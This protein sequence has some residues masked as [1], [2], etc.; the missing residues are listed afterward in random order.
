MRK[1]FSTKKGKDTL[2][3]IFSVGA[4]IVIFGALAKIE[5]WDGIL[6]HALEIGMITETF[7]FMLMAL[8]PPEKEYHWDRFYPNITESLEEEQERTG[9]SRLTPIPLGGHDNQALSSF[10]SMLEKAEITPTNLKKLSDNF[11]KFG[12]TVDKMSEISDVVAATGDYTVRTREA[13]AALIAMR[14]AYAKAAS[15]ASSFHAASESTRAFHEQIQVMTSN[16]ASLNTIYELELQDTN[17]H[18]K[19]MNTFYSNLANASQSMS[20][21]TEDARK[22]QEQIGIL[23]RNLSQLNSVYGNML[24]AMQVR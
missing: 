10:N 12:M 13:A 17:S 16:L 8:I 18:L 7:V 21:S 23:A 5:H 9:Q 1:F 15:A 11:Q 14:D 24:S 3:I 19:V 6:G 20:Q 22:T 4:A 2:N